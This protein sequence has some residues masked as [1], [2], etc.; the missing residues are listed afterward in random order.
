MHVALACSS[1]RARQM[2]HRPL[3]FQHRPL[4]LAQAGSAESLPP[5]FQPKGAAPN[6]PTG[7]V[8]PRVA[9][10]LQT[11]CAWRAEIPPLLALSR[12]TGG[13]QPCSPS[14]SE[15]GFKTEIIP[16]DDLGFRG[17]PAQDAAP[18]SKPSGPSEGSAEQ[19]PGETATMRGRAGVKLALCIIG[20]SVAG[21]N[22]S[23]ASKRVLVTGATSGIR[24][25][26]G[27]QVH[28]DGRKGRFR[29]KKRRSTQRDRAC[30]QGN[31]SRVYDLCRPW[32]V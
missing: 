13:P 29:G 7:R 10:A 18:P 9:K 26:D 24:A 23:M 8:S 14:S 4:L 11:S 15:G 28:R 3:P 21:A 5:P 32:S 1:P 25:R 19:D 6:L 27:R 22:E 20:A 16:R 2:P 17:T 31:W 30:A 12:E